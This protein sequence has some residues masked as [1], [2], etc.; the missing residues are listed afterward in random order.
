MLRFAG[1][2]RLDH[3]SERHEVKDDLGT[4]TPSSLRR[5]AETIEGACRWLTD[6]V[7][8]EGFSLI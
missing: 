4:R 5:Q 1:T 8:N 2:R 7:R 6:I 3:M